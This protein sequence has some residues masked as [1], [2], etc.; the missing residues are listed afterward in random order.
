M[1]ES[2]IMAIEKYFDELKGPEAVFNP[3]PSFAGEWFISYDNL[4]KNAKIENGK[5]L[6]LEFMKKN[7]DEPLFK[8]F[9][10]DFYK[11]FPLEFV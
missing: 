5:N 10:T 2:D 3:I 6:F 1:I 8:L 4:T 7:Y 9:K 11:F